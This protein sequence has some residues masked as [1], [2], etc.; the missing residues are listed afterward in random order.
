MHL[1]SFKYERKTPRYTGI[2]KFEH[3]QNKKEHIFVTQIV[4]NTF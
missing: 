4:D 3:K 1:N 2:N